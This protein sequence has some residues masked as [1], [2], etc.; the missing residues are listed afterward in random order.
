MV[1]KIGPE[2]NNVI[3]KFGGG[4][5]T[6][7]SPDEIDGREAAGGF[8]FTIDIQDRNLKNRPPFDLVGTAPNAGAIRGAAS[9]L[10][11]DGTVTTIFQAG[12][13]IYKWDGHSGFTNVG[14]CSAGCQLRGH[15]KTHVWN[16]SNIVLITDLTLTDTVYQWDGTTFSHP[17]FTDQAGGAFGNFFAKYCAVQDE[18]AVFANVFAGIATP[19]MVVGAKRSVYTQLTVVNRPSS[20]LGAADPFFLLSKDLKPINGYLTTYLGTMISTEKGEIFNLTGTDSTD[21]AF[22]TFY[23]ASCAAGVESI[24]EIG[25]DFIY[26]RPG[27]IESVRDT[28]TFGNS[29]ASDLTEI[30]SDQVAAYTGWTIVFNSRTR[31]TYC[32]PAGVSECWVLDAAIRDANQ[33]SPWMRWKT[34][35]PMAFQPTMVMSLLDPVDGL[36]YV[37]MGDA[38]GHIYRMEGTGA[39]GDGG[40]S[41]ID[42]QF[43][44]KLISARLDAKAYDVEGYIKYKQQLTAAVTLTFQYQGENIF[45]NSLT[46]TLAGAGA[47][48]YWSGTSYWGGTTASPGAGFW[49][50]FTGRL[51]RNKFSIPGNAN[52][53]QVLTEVTGNNAVSINEIG[54]RFRASS[55]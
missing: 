54:I 46:T 4:L 40:T 2:E 44:S 11:T 21:F 45:S 15:W 13:T 48:S 25:N 23:A 27:R 7:A 30:V 39:N 3:L 28:N 33:I 31:K 47:G 12:N 29:T 16:L 26:G 50:S 18:R 55:S 14:S 38:T 49:G 24:E 8:N 52:E 22:A 42:M 20:S 41:T 19:H 43:L 10:K 17:V 9:L 34:S 35:H 36:E 1:S 6:R 5:H 53:F 37:F 51:T 32:F